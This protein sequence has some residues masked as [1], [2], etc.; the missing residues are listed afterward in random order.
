MARWFA[1]CIKAGLSK[2]DECFDGSALNYVRLDLEY[3]GLAAFDP[4]IEQYPHL[5]EI[6]ASSNFLADFEGLSP[7]KYLISLDLSKNSIANLRI[8]ASDSFPC[9]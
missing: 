9:L 5:R 1:E 2:V 3:K 6:K 7:L 4:L 8:L